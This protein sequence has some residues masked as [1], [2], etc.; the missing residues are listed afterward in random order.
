MR[1]DGWYDAHG[2]PE[3]AKGT[4][5]VLLRAVYEFTFGVVTHVGDGNY[6]FDQSA[7]DGG[8]GYH[9]ERRELRMRRTGRDYDGGERNGGIGG[10]GHCGITFQFD[11]GRLWSEH[12]KAEIRKTGDT[13]DIG[14]TATPPS[15]KTQR[16]PM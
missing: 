16:H 15:L 14:R 4:K 5:E 2:D 7:V 6:R 8:R 13:V 10:W 3:E 1:E 11:I 12:E 9:R